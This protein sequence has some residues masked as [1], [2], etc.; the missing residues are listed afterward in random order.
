[1]PAGGLP[2]CALPAIQDQPRVIADGHGGALIAWLDSRG[3]VD[4]APDIYAKRVDVTG[5]VLW[6]VNG[7]QVV[8][9]PMGSALRY[10]RCTGCDTT[11]ALLTRER[12]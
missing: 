4:F 5:A 11:A 2:V 1:M 3:N 7:V 12:K 8:S 10:V 6:T 9:Q